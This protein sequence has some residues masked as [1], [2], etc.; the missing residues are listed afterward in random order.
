MAE[1]H[2]T[3]QEKRDSNAEEN[4]KLRDRTRSWPGSFK[5]ADQRV[6]ELNQLAKDHDDLSKKYKYKEQQYKETEEKLAKA[7]D[8]IANLIKA[9]STKDA[10]IAEVK[11]E[12]DSMEALTEEMSA[13]FPPSDQ[14]ANQLVSAL[15]R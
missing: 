8:L 3:L 7:S 2:H 6:E 1:A 4:A 12:E 11:M 5:D 10:I 14:V 15:Q 13:L 9:Q